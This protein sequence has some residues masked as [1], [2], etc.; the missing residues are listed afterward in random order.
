MFCCAA[1]PSCIAVVSNAG[2]VCPG[3]KDREFKLRGADGIK[4]CVLCN[5]RIKEKAVCRTTKTGI[6]HAKCAKALKDAL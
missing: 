4:V 2:D 6:A 5:K 1:T 3:H